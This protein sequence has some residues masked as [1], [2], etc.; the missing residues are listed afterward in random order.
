MYNSRIRPMLDAID[1]LRSLGVKD[2]GIKLPTIV[3][4]GD[5]SSG[6]TS[7]LESLS[8][9]TLPRGRGICTRVPLILRLQSVYHE[10]FDEEEANL[11]LDAEG[12]CDRSAKPDLSIEEDSAAEES[13]LL[14][15]GSAVLCRSKN[16]T[17]L[18]KSC[19][20]VI[21]YGDVCKEVS[22]SMIE[23]A[24]REAT[25]LLAG[26]GKDIKDS[27]I[28]MTVTRSGAPDLT[29]VDLPGITRVPIEDQPRDIYEQVTKMIRHYI[30]PEESIILNV[31]S[32]AV[33]F[34]TCESIRMSQEV[35][36]TGER[37]LAVV[38]KVD[39]A[40]DGL[41]ER[42]KENA[43]H[44]GLGFVLVRNRTET[45][46]SYEDARRKEEL[47][48]E[49][50]S[51][52]APLREKGMLGVAALA[53][54]LTTIQGERVARSLPKIRQQLGELLAERTGELARLPRGI[55]SEAE[56]GSLLFSLVS[57]K[58]E[59]LQRLMIQGDY[60][61][62]NK[63][64]HFA[65]R[66][67]SMLS[68]FDEE[69]SNVASD[70]A[71]ADYRKRVLDVM[72]CARGVCLPNFMSNPVFQRLVREEVAKCTKVCE[73]IIPV[74]CKYAESVALF[75]NEA[76]M[77]T[78]PFLCERARTVTLEVLEDVEDSC[79]T[80]VRRMLVKAA[81]IIYVS[82]KQYAEMMNKAR[83]I[84][85]SAPAN[86][87]VQSAR[88]MQVS[89][90][91]YW[92][93]LH[94]RLADE[95]PIELKYAVQEA[96][97]RE[98]DRRLLHFAGSDR[99][100]LMELMQEAP[101][102]YRRREGL[103]R[104]IRMLKH[105]VE[106]VFALPQ[107]STSTGPSP[108]FGGRSDVRADTDRLHPSG[109]LGNASEGVA[110]ATTSKAPGYVPEADSGNGTESANGTHMAAALIGTGGRLMMGLLPRGFQKSR[111]PAGNSATDFSLN[112][113]GLNS[114]KVPCASRS[115]AMAGPDYSMGSMPVGGNNGRIF[116]DA[117]C[118]LQDVRLGGCLDDVL[119]EAR[120]AG[121]RWFAVNATTE[122]DWRDV[123]ALADKHPESVAPCFGLHPLFLSS[124]SCQWMPK[125]ESMLRETP[126]AA[127]GEI[128]L[129]KRPICD[130]DFDTQV[131][132]MKAQLQLAKEIG[133]PVS[134]HCVRA[135]G[136]LLRIVKEMG[137]F[138]AGL[139][140]HSYMGSAEMVG[141]FSS[142]GAYFSFSGFIGGLQAKKAEK[143]LQRVPLDRLLLETDCPDALPYVDLGLLQWVPN[144]P[145]GLRQGQSHGA[146]SNVSS[147]KGSMGGSTVGGD[148]DGSGK[149]AFPKGALNHPANITQ[150]LTLV[151]RLA[152]KTEQ[153]IAEAACRNALRLFSY[154][155][156]RI[157]GELPA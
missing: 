95:I 11:D 75:A 28:S 29:L 1:K 92:Q 72:E 56:A 63:S 112:G 67:Y 22:E 133:R 37:T 47:F 114:S 33:D 91:S 126:S 81:D 94:R 147:S 17:T 82:D 90:W 148:G 34:S 53:E 44:V 154:E 123:K 25:N 8:A 40:A 7:V 96:L 43:V 139:I 52:L 27:P 110:V 35:D 73:G 19:K 137:E 50:N 65:A 9:V 30:E 85:P 36:K 106:L 86:A 24:V 98:V 20:V 156:S 111:L 23:S 49:K 142:L 104:S 157:A 79:L 151:A 116:F 76:A 66:I 70:F 155:G 55:S 74:I 60:R 150:V 62:E 153:E 18:K 16:I 77:G 109:P 144:D 12:D 100:Q 31:I 42:I 41:Y 105:G 113:D 121:V 89:L 134:V 143:M 32:A 58:T 138:Q 103:R 152:G 69:L 146:G 39:R 108:L 127:V 88:E 115:S 10:D 128:G 38:T 59:I 97:L 68:R 3:V 57:S 120:V 119:S 136:D 26:T 13:G 122:E 78:Y 45:D 101:A 117:H 6:K 93:I 149:P 71:S 141:P 118:H 99:E 102:T 54:K 14:R 107:W 4:V 130:V 21:E 145:N 131:E 15:S 87:E 84:I 2:E 51:S 48:F 129:D 61:E 140:L 80:F 83:S 124:R 5:Q 125:L 132:V 46:R 135:Y 64:L